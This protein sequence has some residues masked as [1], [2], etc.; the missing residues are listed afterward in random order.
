MEGDERRGGVQNNHFL[1]SRLVRFITDKRLESTRRCQV[2]L[3]TKEQRQPVRSDKSNLRQGTGD[4]SCLGGEMKCPACWQNY[5]AWHETKFLSRVHPVVLF[6]NRIMIDGRTC[7]WR[8]ISFDCWWVHHATLDR[9]HR[10]RSAW[11][12]R[13]AWSRRS[14]RTSIDG[15]HVEVQWAA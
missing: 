12:Q 1:R 2:H 15:A 9:L 11:Q 10:W 13:W 7:Q 14:E 3:T 8:M 6:V 5:R 4:S